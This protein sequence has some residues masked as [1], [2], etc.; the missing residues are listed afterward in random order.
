MSQDAY[1]SLQIDICAVGAE[2]EIDVCVLGAR[3]LLPAGP[4]YSSSEVSVAS[5]DNRAMRL[6]LA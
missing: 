3:A 4:F 5:V 6:R 2:P 1:R